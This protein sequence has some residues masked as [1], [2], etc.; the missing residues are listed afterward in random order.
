MAGNQ[1]LASM[2]AA[3][4]LAG[5]ELLYGNQSGG[6]VKITATQIATFASALTVGTT[7]ISGGTTTRF[8][9][10]L[11]GVL[12]ETAGLTYTAATPSVNFSA[13]ALFP[14]DNTYDIGAQPS[15]RPRTGYFGTALVAPVLTI[16]QGTITSDSSQINGSVTWNNSGIVGPAWK[17]NVTATSANASALLLDLQV[18]SSSKFSVDRTG[19]VSTVSVAASTLTATTLNKVTVTAPASGSTLTIADGKVAT[20]S[21]TLTFTGTDASSVAFGTGG[22]VLFSGGALG[23][24]ASGVLTNCT[25]LSAVTGVGTSAIAN[26]GYIVVTRSVDFNSANTDTAIAIPLPS[27][28]TRY[29][30]LGVNISGASASLTTATFGLFSAAAGGGTAVVASGT[31]CTVNTASEDTATNMQFA[32]VVAISTISHT[33]GTLYFRVQ[34]PQGSAAT[35]IVG[36]QLTPIS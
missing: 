16:T 34:T 1:A 11:A 20:V 8:L 26:A 2:T 33:Y 7:T 25:G 17:L 13:H 22:T 35:A 6:D 4:A 29:R 9:Y 32:T 15:S 3:S 36:L 18:A 27:G 19:A 10:D 24:P 12:S 14:A 30:L 21:N 23:T 28:F 31:A 5:P